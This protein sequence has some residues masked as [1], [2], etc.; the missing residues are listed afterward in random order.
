MGTVLFVRLGTDNRT[1]PSVRLHREEWRRRERL[2]IG[3]K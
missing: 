1:V 2:W 3:R